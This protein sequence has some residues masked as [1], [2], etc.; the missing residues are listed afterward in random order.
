MGFL[1][2]IEI[3]KQGGFLKVLNHMEPLKKQF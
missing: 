1:S 3:Y 2:G